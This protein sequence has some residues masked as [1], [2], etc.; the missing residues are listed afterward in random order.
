MKPLVKL[1][2][3]GL[4]AYEPTWKFQK[5]LVEKVKSERKDNFLIF[6]EHSPV[7]TTGIRSNVYDVNE[8]HRLKNLGAEFY[9]YQNRKYHIVNIGSYIIKDLFKISI[10]LFSG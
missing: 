6:V 8:E 3:L 7:Y 4:R 9:R 1:L 5:Q 2:R 10:Y